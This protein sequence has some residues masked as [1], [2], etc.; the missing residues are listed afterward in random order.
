[1]GEREKIKELRDSLACLGV[2]GEGGG[3]EGDE[4]SGSAGL[5]QLEPPGLC[6]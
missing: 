4:K 3:T 5:N 6:V 2:G 1:M